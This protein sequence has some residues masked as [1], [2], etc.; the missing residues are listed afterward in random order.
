MRSWLHDTGYGPALDHEG[1][2]TLVVEAGT[3]PDLPPDQVGPRVIG[4]RA[5]CQCGWRGTRFFLRAEWRTAD[6]AIAPE[7]V[8][9]RCRADWE[10]HL[11]AALPVLGIHDLT[12]RVDDA[13]ENL[14]EAVRAARAAGVG[15]TLI[16]EA[17]GISGAGAKARW[18]DATRPGAPP[19][20]LAGPC[21]PVG[22][23]TLQS[24]G[25]RRPTPGGDGLPSTRPGNRLVRSQAAESPRQLLGEPEQPRRIR[26]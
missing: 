3:D 11:R 6:C 1:G 13:R 9:E 14:V 24:L 12:R 20:R 17:A 26:L 2:V 19:N 15:W 18:S 4:W 5:G 7:Q 25:C 8:A 16:G 21:R 23:P 22:P 10:R